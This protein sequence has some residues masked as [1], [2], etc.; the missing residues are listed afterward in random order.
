MPRQTE[1]QKDEWKDGRMDGQTLFY[2][3]YPATARG[4]KKSS[5]LHIGEH[6]KDP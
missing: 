4:P 1:G 2:R 6:V 5:N 3:T